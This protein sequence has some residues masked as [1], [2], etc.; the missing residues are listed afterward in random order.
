MATRDNED[1][2]LAC[3]LVCEGGEVPLPL[4][5]TNMVGCFIRRKQQVSLWL[6]GDVDTHSQV[7]S[8]YLMLASRTLRL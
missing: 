2:C 4:D 5:G 6:V 1:E 7:S 3:V 8:T